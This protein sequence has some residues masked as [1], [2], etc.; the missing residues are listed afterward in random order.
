MRVLQFWLLTKRVFI[1]DFV[2][3]YLRCAISSGRRI[4]FRLT[5]KQGGF[6]RSNLCIYGRV[7]YYPYSALRRLAS[8][9]EYPIMLFL[10]Q[11][12]NPPNES[13]KACF[14]VTTCLAMIIEVKL[15]FIKPTQPISQSHA[16][17]LQN[18]RGVISLEKLSLAKRNSY[19]HEPPPPFDVWSLTPK[20]PRRETKH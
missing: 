13:P 10:V 6:P 19:S 11:V 7:L 3:I 17:H 1:F 14:Q 15:H 16:S 2:G 18:L 20:E 8:F 9:Q 12:R 4:Q 5:R